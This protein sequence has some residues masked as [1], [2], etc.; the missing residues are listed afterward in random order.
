MI[1]SIHR[2]SAQSLQYHQSFQKLSLFFTQPASKIHRPRSLHND[3]HPATHPHHNRRNGYNRRRR[4]WNS[5]PKAVPTP[6]RGLLG[7][8][9]GIGY[10]C[11]STER[12]NSNSSLD[13]DFHSRLW[14]LEHL[15]PSE[16]RQC[17]SDL[18]RSLWYVHRGYNLYSLPPLI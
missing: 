5:S 8:P 15:H 13:R 4:P 1:T 7:R 6:I 9:S 18:S 3:F 17:G 10:F 12:D 14:L 2:Q 11:Q 16:S